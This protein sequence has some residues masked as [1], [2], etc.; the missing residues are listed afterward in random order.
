MVFQ[1]HMVC[2]QGSLNMP[3]GKNGW[4]HL[5][6]AFTLALASTMALIS[7][8]KTQEFAK[9]ATHLCGPET[10]RLGRQILFGVPKL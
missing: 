6:P 8:S 7:L 4:A 3:R 9:H 1:V 2:V 5:P 10:Q